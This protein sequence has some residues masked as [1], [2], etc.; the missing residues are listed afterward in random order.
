[1][2]ITL[3]DALEGGELGAALRQALTSETL[4]ADHRLREERFAP[5]QGCFECWVKHPG[6]CKAKDAANDVMRDAMA[7]DVLLWATRVRFGCWDP[8]AK[9]AFDKAV[10]VLSP[11]FRAIAGETH[12]AKRYARYP[13]M[14]VLAVLPKDAP[15]GEAE[16]FR[17]LVAR[18]AA[19]FHAGAPWVGF[20]GEGDPPEAVRAALAEGLDALRRPR[21]ETLPKVAAF[22]ED[23]R[24][25]VPPK[26]GPR[27]VALWI[28]SAKPAGTSASEALA[29]LLS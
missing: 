7:A 14:G 8:I 26:A 10:G 28:G 25:G 6:T 16:T 4:L 23:V 11:F 20:V 18:N 21:D 5:C 17:R 29:V 12:H 24:Q 13:R 3:L 1:M 15:P 19:N 9:V 2:K 27:H 22:A